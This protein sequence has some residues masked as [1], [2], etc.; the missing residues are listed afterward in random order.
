M[1]IRIRYSGHDAE[2][3][4]EDCFLSRDEMFGPFQDVLEA[5]TEVI[6]A[7][8]HKRFGARKTTGSELVFL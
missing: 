1:R 6:R 4:L 3:S 2:C 7:Y 5:V 8:N